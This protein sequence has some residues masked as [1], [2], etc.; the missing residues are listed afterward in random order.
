MVLATTSIAAF[1]TPFLSSAIA[2]AVPRIGVSFHLDFI[3]AAFIPMVFLIPLASFMIFFG[4]ISDDVGRAR[5]DMN[6]NVQSV[7][8]PAAHTSAGIYA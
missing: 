7:F 1:A 6:L 3:E 2:F 4:R 5:Q 8:K